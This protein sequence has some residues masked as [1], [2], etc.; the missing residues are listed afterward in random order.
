[1][2]VSGRESSDG[3][4]LRRKRTEAEFTVPYLGE[5]LVRP[6]K[7]ELIDLDENELLQIPLPAEH[8]SLV[9]AYGKLPRDD[10]T[11]IDELAWKERG[12]YESFQ[13]IRAR[14]RT[15]PIAKEPELNVFLNSS[16]VFSARRTSTGRP[17]SPESAPRAQSLLD[18]KSKVEGGRG[19]SPKASQRQQMHHYHHLL[20]WDRG[21]FHLPYFQKGS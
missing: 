16:D 19:N 2:H 9:P 4:G 18:F 6:E 1:M 3:S 17:L 10:Q 20:H 21:R 11:A 5:F 14:M 12:S 13:S 8:E 15:V 7:I